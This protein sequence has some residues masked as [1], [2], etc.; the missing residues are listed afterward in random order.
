M[1]AWGR[2]AGA[3]R[4]EEE[5][6][7]EE[8]AGRGGGTL[9]R[10]GGGGGLRWPPA[11][12]GSGPAPPAPPRAAPPVWPGL[13]GAGTT[14]RPGR[15]SGGG[16]S[17]RSPPGPQRGSRPPGPART[18]PPR[19]PA[20]LT[21]APAER[22]EAES[23]EGQPVALSPALAGRAGRSGP[24]R[25]RR[26]PGECPP[27]SAG[28]RRFVA[29]PRALPCRGGAVRAWSGGGPTGAFGGRYGRR[30]LYFVWISF[31]PRG[32]RRSPAWRSPEGDRRP[33]LFLGW[34]G[35]GRAAFPQAPVVEGGRVPSSSSSRG[36]LFVSPVVS[37]PAAVLTLR[38]EG[39]GS[40]LGLEMSVWR[41]MERWRR[42]VVQKGKCAYFR[43]GFHEWPTCF[44]C[45]FNKSNSQKDS[46]VDQRAL[47]L[48]SWL[49]C[50]LL[51][52]TVGLCILEHY[53]S[54]WNMV[55]FLLGKVDVVCC[56]SRHN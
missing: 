24:A 48:F 40:Q 49:G 26:L 4:E 46:S 38:D 34:R 41:E 16:A 2:A 11:A 42:E 32:P 8:A 37:D 28:P 21:A 12:K 45:V 1:A 23:G 13:D 44:F 55:G 31:S 30:V 56:V 53:V 25:A 22:R 20:R 52:G 6:R 15:C 43:L 50:V 27:P 33:L 3:S 18:A 47:C 14:P 29:P 7:R 51:V 54:P 39:R 9:R 35:P 17:R 10:G 36:C 19:P 5:E